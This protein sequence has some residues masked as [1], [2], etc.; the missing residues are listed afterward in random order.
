MSVRFFCEAHKVKVQVLQNRPKLI[1]S[2]Y[3]MKMSAKSI[4]RLADCR[5]KMIQF[6]K[7]P[8]ASNQLRN[9]LFRQLQSPSLLNIYDKVK[10]TPREL[11]TFLL[12]SSK[13]DNSL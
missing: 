2:I 1:Y 8:W 7:A 13:S 12:L 4:G 5:I 9:D 11:K 6:P 10:V 3:E